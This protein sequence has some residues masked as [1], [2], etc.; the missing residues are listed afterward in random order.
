MKAKKTIVKEFIKNNELDFDGYGSDLNGN[1][2]ILAGFICYI[3][4]E[5]EKGYIIIENLDIKDEAREELIR[6]YD[7]A[8]L[9]NYGAFWE[10]PEAKEQYKF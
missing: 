4:E 7:Y 3:E 8:Y 1:C 6:V 9:S 10:T 2:T 5:L